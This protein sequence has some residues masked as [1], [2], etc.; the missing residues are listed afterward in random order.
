MTGPADQRLAEA[1][2]AEHAAI[3]GYGL[4]GAHLDGAAL[5]LVAQVEA[6]HRDRRDALL[7]RLTSRGAPAPAAELAYTVPFAVTDRAS[8][9]RLAVTIEER[10]AAVWRA[11]LPQTV[12]EERSFTLD[13]LTDCALRAVRLRLAAGL[14]PA[15]AVL[16]GAQT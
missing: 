15:T 2:R 10:T 11:A 9:L 16:P 5:G 12:R 13:A 14:S 1:L 3:F 4:I 7:L 6:A 8:A